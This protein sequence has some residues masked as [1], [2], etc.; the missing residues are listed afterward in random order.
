MRRAFSI[1]ACFAVAA[2]VIGDADLAAAREKR[3]KHGKASSEHREGKPYRSST[4]G[5]NGA[6]WR[7]TGRPTDSLNLNH[8]C[9]R[10][11]FWARMNDRS[12]DRN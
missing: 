9:D 11:E 6:C 1:A 4:V 3:S 12:N 5:P 2:L 7:D 10:E 8:Q